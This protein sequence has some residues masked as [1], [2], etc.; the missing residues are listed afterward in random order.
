MTKAVNLREGAVGWHR[1]SLVRLVNCR[2]IQAFFERKRATFGSHSWTLSLEI[3]ASL[4]MPGVVWPTTEI[5]PDTK[6]FL[7]GN[8]WWKRVPGEVVS[9]IE[10]VV[11]DEEQKDKVEAFFKTV[12]PQYDAETVARRMKRISVVVKKVEC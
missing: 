8:D 10:V 2:P 9:S 5:L 11:E 7:M 6:G 1:L 4:L 3:S 12:D